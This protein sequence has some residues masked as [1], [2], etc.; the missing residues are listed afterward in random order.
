MQVGN[1]DGY[2]RS[3]KSVTSA[4]EDLLKLKLSCISFYVLQI[5]TTKTLKKL[6]LQSTPG[7][8]LCVPT[9]YIYIIYIY[10]KTVSSKFLTKQDCI[11]SSLT[12]TC[13]S[14]YCLQHKWL[15]FTKPFSCFDSISKKLKKHCGVSVN[16]DLIAVTL[17]TTDWI[18]YFTQL[19]QK[20]QVGRYLPIL[21][22]FYTFVT[23][24][25]NDLANPSTQPLPLIQPSPFGYIGGWDFFSTHRQVIINISFSVQVRSTKVF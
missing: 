1:H 18:H 16:G 23:L 4:V 19:T 15:L 20:I 10:K 25:G 7:K 6:Q 13:E 8:A 22:Y 21:Y 5:I 12:S 11:L 3:V 14:Q 24:N 2:D 9:L 17:H